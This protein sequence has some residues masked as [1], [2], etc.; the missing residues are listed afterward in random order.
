M[1]LDVNACNYGI[2]IGVIAFLALMGLLFIDAFI[3][4]LIDL[5]MKKR[6]IIIDLAFTALWALLWFIGFCYMTNR[7]AIT[8]KTLFQF[9]PGIVT[10]V[11]SA[12]AFTFFSVITWVRLFTVEAR[13]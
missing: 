2:A 8:E 13:I 6:I 1:D 5:N 11:N 10:N 7:W 9:I 4:R 3:D 12:L